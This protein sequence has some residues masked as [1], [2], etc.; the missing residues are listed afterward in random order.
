MRFLQ[1][2]K[3]TAQV[4]VRELGRKAAI[5]LVRIYQALV[6]PRIGAKCLYR[7]SCSEYSIMALERYPLRTALAM[8][9]ARIRSCGPDQY[10][11]ELEQV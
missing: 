6:S 3:W 10:R 7:F 4:G 5:T 1:R 9:V 8:T 2:L 11:A